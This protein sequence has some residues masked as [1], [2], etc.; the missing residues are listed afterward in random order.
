MAEMGLV[1][2]NG[3][4]LFLPDD[5]VTQQEYYIM[6]ARAAMYLNVNFEFMGD[7]ITEEQMEWAKESGFRLWARKSA[8]LLDMMGVLPVEEGLLPAQPILRETAA[9][10]LYG[11]LVKTGV[12]PG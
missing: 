4:G 12:L 11:V 2:G 7:D 10:S 5:P 8:T 1:V 9:V 6:L 3:A